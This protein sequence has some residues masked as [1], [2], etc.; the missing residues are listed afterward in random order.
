MTGRRAVRV[1]EDW[2]GVLADTLGGI[3]L[4]CKRGDTLTVVAEAPGR[5]LCRTGDG[6][7]GWVPLTHLV[8]VPGW[9]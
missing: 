2:D 4:A 3:G 7:E 5:A 1:R 8:N 6:T 9:P